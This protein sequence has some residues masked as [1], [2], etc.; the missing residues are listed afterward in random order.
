M[1]GPNTNLKF[2]N[3]YSSKFAEIAFH[4]LIKAGTCNLHIVYG[5]LQ[6]SESA[7]GWGLKNMK[8]GRREDYASVTGS[9]ICP[10]NFCGTRYNLLE[11]IYC[12]TNLLDLRCIITSGRKRHTQKSL[13]GQIS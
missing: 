13:H 8:K 2:F 11:T 4:S 5:S 3:E 9:S 7:Y 10:F 6:T 12:F 1:E